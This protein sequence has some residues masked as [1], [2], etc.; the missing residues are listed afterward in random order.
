MNDSLKKS[1]SFIQPSDAAQ[2]AGQFELDAGVIR[3]QF[4]RAL[5]RLGSFLKLP[6]AIIGTTQLVEF[7]RFVIPRLPSDRELSFGA[8]SERGQFK[9]IASLALGHLPFSSF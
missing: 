4:E 6:L 3:T 8:A 1:S 5:E 2:S 9:K 7:S